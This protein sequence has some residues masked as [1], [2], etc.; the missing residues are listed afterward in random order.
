MGPSPFLPSASQ[1]HRENWALPWPSEC[2][3]ATEVLMQLWAESSPSWGHREGQPLVLPPLGLPRT[4]SLCLAT[5]RHQLKPLVACSFAPKEGDW[6]HFAVPAQHGEFSQ[7]ENTPCEAQGQAAWGKAPMPASCLH[8]TRQGDRG[9]QELS[10]RRTHTVKA[11][12]G[13]EVAALASP[14]PVF[15]V[16]CVA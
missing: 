4:C 15:P 3:D 8:Q 2:R 7:W 14:S 9:R 6:A 12:A 11:S 1:G 5:E 13:T 16:R 10:R